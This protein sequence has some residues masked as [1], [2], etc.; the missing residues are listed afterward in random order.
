MKLNKN[1]QIVLE[2]LKNK[3]MRDTS[4]FYYTPFE[5]IEYTQD[6]YDCDGF[7]TEG[8]YEAMEELTEQQQ[9]E[10]LQAFAEWGCNSF[11]NG[12]NR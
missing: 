12:G 3:N 6:H 2:E 11:Q 9:F 4:G 8:I 1:Q 7:G 10:V 5:A